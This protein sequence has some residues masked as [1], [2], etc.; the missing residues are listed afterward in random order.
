[1]DAP[2]EIR[3]ENNELTRGKQRVENIKVYL[4]KNLASDLHVHS[5]AEK[6]KLSIS[7]F[8]HLF[9]KYQGQPYRKYLEEI[10]INKAFNLLKTEGIRIK[11]VMY[12]TGY[13]NRSTFNNAFKKR[14]KHPPGYF[15]K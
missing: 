4:S 7:S 1:M 2:N 11:E 10:R 5:V 8:H 13:K 12:A 9:K 6:F 14:F 15:K 3:H